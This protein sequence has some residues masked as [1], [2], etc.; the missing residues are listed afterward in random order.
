MLLNDT[1]YR[2]VD[3]PVGAPVTILRPIDTIGAHI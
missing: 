2:Y 3:V 1:S